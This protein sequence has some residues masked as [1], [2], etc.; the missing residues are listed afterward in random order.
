MTNVA[1]EFS[2]AV[3]NH[4]E[5]EYV[6]FDY[7]APGGTETSRFGEIAVS[8]ETS[9]NG[10]LLVVAFWKARPA[11]SPLYDFP[12]GDESGF[13][14]EGSATIELLDSGETVELHPGDLYTFRKNTL[15]RWTIHQPFTKFV[16]VND[17]PAAS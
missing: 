9:H 8:R 17:G 5:V 4:E 6:P 16:V 7:P 12:L 2:H 11:T 15:S 1:S 14:I 10:N 13:V 3:R